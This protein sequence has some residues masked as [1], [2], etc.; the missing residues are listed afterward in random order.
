MEKI[1]RKKLVIAFCIL[2]GSLSIV[3]TSFVCY[4][5]GYTI[6]SVF[7]PVN[8]EIFEISDKMISE[9]HYGLF[10]DSKFTKDGKYRVTRIG[11]LYVI[12]IENFDE[13]TDEN[14]NKIL[15]A[16]KNHYKNSS[17]VNSVYICNGGTVVLDCRL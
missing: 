9:C 2:F 12:R 16:A 10:G 14:Y 1:D 8:K 6:S 3:L 17:L 13:S 4:S 11:R 7:N 15:K 5:K